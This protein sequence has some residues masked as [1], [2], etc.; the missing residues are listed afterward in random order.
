MKPPVNPP[1]MTLT[2]DAPSPLPPKSRAGCSRFLLAGCLVLLVLC[3]LGAVLFVVNASKVAGWLLV[4]TGNELQA[5]LPE[6][7][8]A[9]ERQRLGRG[10]AAAGRGVAEGDI[11]ILEAQTLQRRMQS[12][13][14][15]PRG[16]ITAVDV[17]NLS[18][19]LE[20]ATSRTGTPRAVDGKAE[21]AIEGRIED[22]VPPDREP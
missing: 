19:A 5:R 2:P 9:D 6:E 15:K 3:A 7:I 8:T 11:D 12:L 16:E 14:A 10:V 21:D 4:K 18:E 13:L 20:E 17:R 1:K 22:G